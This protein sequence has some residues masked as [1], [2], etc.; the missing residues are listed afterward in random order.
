MGFDFF[1]VR[2]FAAADVTVD[3]FSEKKSE[4]DRDREQNKPKKTK[5]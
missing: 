5:Q 4:Q 2:S 3:S 1:F